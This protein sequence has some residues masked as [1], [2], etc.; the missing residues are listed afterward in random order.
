MNK[1]ECEACSGTGQVLD[2]EVCGFCEPKKPILFGDVC[3]SDAEELRDIA[4]YFEKRGKPLQG[5]FLRKVADRH[6]VLAGAYTTASE[7][8]K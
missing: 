3:A 4:A 6:E 8:R 2:G 1:D 5:K 7:R